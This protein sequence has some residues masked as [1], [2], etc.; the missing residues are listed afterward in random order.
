MD[1][2]KIAIQKQIEEDLKS[3]SGPKVIRYAIACLSGL[4]LGEKG[5]GVR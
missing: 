2:E 5:Q 3:G 4:I 1:N